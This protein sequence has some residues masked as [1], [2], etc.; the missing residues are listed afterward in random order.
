M[1]ALYLRGFHQTFSTVCDILHYIRL[2][3]LVY[4]LAQLRDKELA[5]YIIEQSVD[6]VQ[7]VLCK[8]LRTEYVLI[9]LCSVPPLRIFAFLLFL[10]LMLCLF[11]LTQSLVLIRSNKAVKVRRQLEFL[12]YLSECRDILRHGKFIR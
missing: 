7:R 6:T 1:V 3:T 5:V 9:D 8:K 2:D 10:F 11:E 12:G 4:D